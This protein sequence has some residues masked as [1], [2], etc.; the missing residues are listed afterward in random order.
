[1]PKALDDTSFDLITCRRPRG[2]Q[3]GR[4][5]HERWFA[6]Y[7]DAIRELLKMK[8]P[9]WRRPS[10]TSGRFGIVVGVSW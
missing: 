1:M 5:G 9:Y 6:E 7:D 10:L 3:V 8:R 2:Y 4:K